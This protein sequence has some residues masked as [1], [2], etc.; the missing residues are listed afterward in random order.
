[1]LLV[2]SCYLLGSC[3]AAKF[4]SKIFSLPDPSVT[5]SNNLGATNV[6]RLGGAKP[7]VFT[8][9]WDLGK[10]S[11][12]TFIS[13]YCASNLYVALAGMLAVLLG[14]LYPLFYKFKGGKGV[15][16]ACGILLVLSWPLALCVIGTWIII[17][18]I[19]RISSLAA[20][21]AAIVAPIVA[22][23]YFFVDARFYLV[24][25]ITLMLL[26]KHRT[27]IKR[28]LKGKENKIKPGS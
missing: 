25:A 22:Y 10:G 15:A 4:F 9:I 19:F 7:A 1:M 21:V 13:L 20:I 6:Y 24:L 27:N 8:L 16:T 23:F 28:L 17:F 26:I 11:I 12:A 14:H 3:T 18:S 5:G 2:V